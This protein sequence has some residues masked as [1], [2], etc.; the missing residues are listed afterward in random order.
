MHAHTHMYTQKRLVWQASPLICHVSLFIYLFICIFT[1]C[2]Q[3]IALSL[4]FAVSTSLSVSSLLRSLPSVLFAPC[5]RA[6][7]RSGPLN[8]KPAGWYLSGHTSRWRWRHVCWCFYMGLSLKLECHFAFFFL[9]IS[10]HPSHIQDTD[11]YKKL[12]RLLW[13]IHLMHFHNHR[14]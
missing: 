2:L 13:F 14:F 1:F 6:E 5:P 11:S 4:S 3:L 9:I 10:I 12:K 8:W 7:P